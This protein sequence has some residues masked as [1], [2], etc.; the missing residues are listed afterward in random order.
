[1]RI[2]LLHLGLAALPV[3]G[4]T[5]LLPAQPPGVGPA[6]IPP[7]YRPQFGNTTPIYR[8][9]DVASNDHVYARD[10]NEVNMLRWQGSHRYEG[11]A[12][13]TFADPQPGTRPLYRFVRPDGKHLLD[14]RRSTPDPR[15]RL[16]DL[17]GYIAAEPRPGLVPLTAWVNPRDGLFFYTTDPRGEFAPNLGYRNEGV[18]GYVLPG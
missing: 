2:H 4:L 11:V 6:P 3:L 9:L 15:A 7:G 5:A 18:L 17:L 8:M 16:E 12:C 14:T 10:P 13:Q 1:M